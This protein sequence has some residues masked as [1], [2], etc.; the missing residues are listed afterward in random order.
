[1]KTTTLL[2]CLLGFTL[3]AHAAAPTTPPAPAKTE[4][5]P[6]QFDL[7][8][9]KIGQT[10][11]DHLNGRTP[12]AVVGA[13][14]PVAQPT[15]RRGASSVEASSLFIHILPEPTES[16]SSVEASTV[17]E[18]GVYYENFTIATARATLMVMFEGDKFHAATLFKGQSTTDLKVETSAQKTAAYYFKVKSLRAVFSSSDFELIATAMINKYGPAKKDDETVQNVFGTKF[19]NAYLLWQIGDVFLLL[20]RYGDD[21]KHGKFIATSG[22]AAKTVADKAAKDL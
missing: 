9:I 5:K 7:K 8:G 1:M 18:L 16:A 4:P 20:Q 19:D 22:Q 21:L 3:C 11:S 10:L 12:S 14:Q 6:A 13:A 2:A 17:P 15:G